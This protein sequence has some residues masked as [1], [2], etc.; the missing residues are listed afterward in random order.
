MKINYDNPRTRTMSFS[1]KLMGGRNKFSKLLAHYGVQ[2]TQQ[3]VTMWVVN[4]MFP[5]KYRHPIRSLIEAHEKILHS[6]ENYLDFLRCIQLPNEKKPYRVLQ[7]PNLKLNIWIED[8]GGINDLV[9]MANDQAPFEQLINYNTVHY[10][11]KRGYIPN[12][13]RYLQATFKIPEELFK[14]TPQPL[15]PESDLIG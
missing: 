10:W 5:F 12:E 11:K 9:Y 2:V 4:G 3:T 14:P 13:Y 15:N 7:Y 6:R 8:R 1:I